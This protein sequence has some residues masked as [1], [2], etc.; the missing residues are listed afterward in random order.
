M[1][2]DEAR[3]TDEW[4]QVIKSL[5]HHAGKIGLYPIHNEKPLRGF[6]WEYKVNLCF[7]QLDCCDNGV[8]DGLEGDKIEGQFRFCCRD[9]DDLGI[10]LTL[11]RHLG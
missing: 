11:R 8:D 9:T 1:S 4:S 7:S 3:E 10:C 2:G 6:K 5:V